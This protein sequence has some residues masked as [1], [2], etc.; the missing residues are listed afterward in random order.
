MKV[1]IGQAGVPISCKKRDTLSGIECTHELGLNLMEIQF[2]RRVGMKEEVMEQIREKAEE[3]GV[4][5]SIHAPYYI[6]LASERKEVIKRS[7]E[8]WIFNSAKIGDKI[9]AKWIV[10]HPAAYGKRSPEETFDLVVKN[11]KKAL[12]KIRKF[13]V[14]LCP[15]TTGKKGQ[16]GS[17]SEILKLVKRIKHPKLL[18]C[19]DFAHMH[20]RE[21]G[22]FYSKKDYSKIFERIEKELGE[23][24]LKTLHI[25]FSCIKYTE[26]GEKEH[27]ELKAK[28]PDFSKFAEALKE[29]EAEIE[30]INIVSE[31]PILEKD[32]IK[33]KKILKRKGIIK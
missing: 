11:L 27:L 17:F 8:E 6:N 26:R 20:A 4:R 31:S 19:L 24:Y 22:W 5:L 32:A 23:K 1:Y 13:K 15:E 10:F 2:V 29:W 16:F 28:E 14:Y 18:F 30:E 33:M 12:E 7:I 3:L 21:G 9:G 25:H